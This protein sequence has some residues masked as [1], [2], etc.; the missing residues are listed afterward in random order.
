MAGLLVVVGLASPRKVSRIRYNSVI[1]SG[2][3]KM[4]STRGQAVVTT[5]ITIGCPLTLE[6][7]GL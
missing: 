3:L 6:N 1:V 2:Q 7:R 5:V 4:M